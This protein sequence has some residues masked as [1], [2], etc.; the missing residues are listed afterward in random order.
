MYI[1]PLEKRIIGV[2]GHYGSGKTEFA[3]SLANLLAD[4]PKREYPRLAVVDL[5]IA[6][7]Y[8][9]SRERK[10]ELEAKGIKVIGSAYDCEITAELPALSAAAR[11]PLEDEGCRVI[12]DFGGNDVGA[13]VLHQFRKYF[14]RDQHLLLAVV[15]ASRAETRTIEGALEHLAAIEY[16]TGLPLD[17][18]INNCHLLRETDAD[19]VARGHRFCTQLCEKM[20]LPLYCDCYPAPLVKAGSLHDIGPWAM[21][22]GLYMRPSWLDKY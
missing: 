3:V 11:G 10:E 8:F 9:R 5:D 16:A 22:L 4:E 1:K 21:P 13:L 20:G 2:T 15:N 7:P 6:N 14:Q 12:V 18:L 19:D 17:G